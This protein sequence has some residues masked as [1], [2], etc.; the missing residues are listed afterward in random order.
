M[1]MPSKED[2]VW[3]DEQIEKLISLSDQRTKTVSNM[4]DF[5]A[6]RYTLVYTLASG[7]PPF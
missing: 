2:L 3:A 1:P 6:V 7:R 4:L 5:N